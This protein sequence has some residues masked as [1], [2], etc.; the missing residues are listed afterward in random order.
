MRCMPRTTLDFLDSGDDKSR[1]RLL[2]G[3]TFHI[4]MD[5]TTQVKKQTFWGNAKP[6]TVSELSW[7]KDFGAYPN[8]NPSKGKLS[9]RVHLEIA[10]LKQ[11]TQIIVYY[12][13]LHRGRTMAQLPYWILI[14]DVPVGVLLFSLP[15]LSVPLDG[16][17]P[18]N[19]L[20]LARVW[21]SPDVQQHT[22]IDSHGSSHAVSVAS[23]AIGKALRRARQDWLRR[24]PNLPDIWV[25][26][27]WADTEHH[28]GIIY[29]AAN[30]IA[31]GKSGGA[32]HGNRSRPNGGRDQYNLDYAH[33]KTR[34]IYKYAQPLTTAEKSRV[35]AENKK[36]PQMLLF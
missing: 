13:Y 17:P 6:P 1:P 31:Q 36:S 28:E 9:R 19:V 23:C 24:Y 16:I 4:S 27:S 11:A 12:H 32:M 35:L 20:E 14:D 33:T 3:Q 18:M 22:L 8:F 26:V 34:F 30:F 10:N 2:N 5:V 29:K 15:R 21:I 25:V 7:I